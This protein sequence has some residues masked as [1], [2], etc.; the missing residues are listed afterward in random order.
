MNW[1][2]TAVDWFSFIMRYRVPSF[3][4]FFFNQNFAEG[5]NVVHVARITA[6]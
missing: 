6:S 4:E 1:G 5:Y 2:N 3:T